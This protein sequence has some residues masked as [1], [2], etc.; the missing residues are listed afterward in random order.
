MNAGDLP[1]LVVETLQVLHVHRRPDIHA[2][3]Q[4]FQ[5]VLPS[6]GAFR[7]GHVGVGQLVDETHGGMAG[8]DRSGVHLLECHPSV[9]DL[10]SGHGFKTLRLIDGVLAAMGFEIADSH[11]HA[12]P[13]QLL[14][15]LEHPEGLADTRGI[16]QENLEASSPGCAGAAHCTL[17]G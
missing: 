9:L 5:R 1:H 6:L 17:F 16:A 2:G 11:V 14:R 15:L 3:V 12:P 4:Q 8:H 13:L 7:A 10:A